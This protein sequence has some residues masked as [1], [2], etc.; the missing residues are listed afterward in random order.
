MSQ[1]QDPK[2]CDCFVSARRDADC[3]TNNS[4]VCLARMATI[5]LDQE[6][7]SHIQRTRWFDSVTAHC[8]EDFSATLLKLNARF[9][10][11]LS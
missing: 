11:N 1:G 10:C 4:Q 9:Y 6:V 7:R 8:S 3:S 2:T 5:T